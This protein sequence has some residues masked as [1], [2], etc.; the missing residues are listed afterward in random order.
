MA[1]QL[2]VEIIGDSKRFT[3][4]LHDATGSTAGFGG[5]IGG[6][7]SSLGPYAAGIG[8]VAGG[9]AV[10]TQSAL[11]DQAE[12]A[13]LAQVLKN[14][15][16]ANKDQVAGVEK[17]LE[18]MMKVS[19]FTDS[20]LRPAM[21]R[22]VTSTKDADEASKLLT[23]AMDIAAATGKPLQTVTDAL[24]KAHD[25]NSGAL[26]RLGIQTKDAEGKT[27]SFEQIMKNATQTFGGSAQS[28]ADTT[29]G[30]MKNLKRDLGELGEKIG[31][32][33]IPVVASLTDWF[34]NKA[35]P[36]I[37]E[38][39]NNS[40][41][42]RQQI[43]DGFG[44][45]SAAVK[46]AWVVI[47]P[48]LKAWLELQKAILGGVGKVFD[49]GRS[50]GGI[51]GNIAGRIPGFAAGGSISGPAIVGERGPELFMPSGSGRIV[52]NNQLGGSNV[53]VIVQGS[54]TSERN[55]VDAIHS[56]LLLKQGRGP[57]L[58]LT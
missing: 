10:L 41:N 56:G 26:A 1:R 55:L 16:G 32:A 15:T 27:L 39:W 42:L 43:E 18:A 31:S 28:A 35:V 6:V 46:I 48:I 57:A 58:G 4:S 52:P 47:E 33:L 20:E 29:A 53:T 19:T 51:V 5:K 17:Q 37:I 9:L 24:A 13:K 11:E 8:A 38:L 50:I 25:G 40:K 14:V 2:V 45:I 54:V 12:Q 23:T 3:K 34:L 44:R 49:V 22:L 36:A 30:K 21:S 7:I